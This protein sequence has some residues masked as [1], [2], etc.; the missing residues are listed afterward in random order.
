MTLKRLELLGCDLAQGY[1][2]GRPVPSEVFLESLAG[3]PATWS[4]GPPPP[5]GRQRPAADSVRRMDSTFTPFHRGGSGLPLVCVH[6]FA[7]TWRTW[8]LVLPDLER[9]HDVLALTLAGHAGGPPISGP[10]DHKSLVD[11]AERAMDEAGFETA[12]VVGNSLGGFLSLQL[13]ARGR[14]LT[15]VALAPA[16]G[17][18]ERDPLRRR[19]ARSACAP[20]RSSSGPP[21][22]TPTRSSRQRRAE[23]AQR[24]TPP[25]A[26]STS[27][28]TCSRT[29][30]VAR[31][32][33]MPPFR[34]STSPG[35]TVTDSTPRRSRALCGSCG[36]PKTSCCPGRGRRRATATGGSRT[37]TGSSSTEWATRLSSTSPSRRRS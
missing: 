13:A 26:S 36:A 9:R 4:P 2:L 24:L 35:P 34:C 3:R 12:H 22:P 20:C 6:G 32:A 14:A 30:S 25:P 15:V 16:S 8:E 27:R 18:P 17:W 28:L 7:D 10:I 19:R 23:G 1:H 5:D 11:A 21:R 33:A 37:P 31:R 29:R